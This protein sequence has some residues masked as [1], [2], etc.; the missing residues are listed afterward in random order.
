MAYPACNFS[1]KA[2]FAGDFLSKTD[3]PW[4]R[5]VV[6]FLAS[7]AIDSPVA[8]HTLPSVTDSGASYV[9]APMI[10]LNYIP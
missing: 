8:I 7:R 3:S 1:P 2:G 4:Y 6:I 5:Q 9:I 10:E